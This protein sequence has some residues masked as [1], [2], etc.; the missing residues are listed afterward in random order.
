MKGVNEMTKVEINGNFHLLKQK[1]IS[2]F[3]MERYSE[4]RRKWEN[5][6]LRKIVDRFPIHLDI[7]ATSACNLKCPFCITTHANFENGL[8]KDEMFQAIIDEGSE[9]GLCS[10][11]LN[12]RGEPLVHPK[13]PEMI[14]YAKAKGIVDVFLNTNAAFLT[15]TKSRQLINAG[16]DRIIISFEGYEKDLYESQRVGAI[17]EETVENVRNFMIIRREL[18]KTLPWVRIQTVLLDE[19]ENKQADYADFWEE[20]VDEVAYVDLKNEVNRIAVGENDWVCPQLWQRLTISWDGRIMPCVNDTFCNM[21]LGKILKTSI[22]DVWKSERLQEM[23]DLH[24]KGLAHT[25]KDCLDCP[26][27]SAQVSR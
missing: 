3:E 9:K 12:W 10:I 16:V 25:I 4:Y 21:C 2:P 26:L 18:N 8:M 27:R 5:Y 7:E 24:T 1:G 14:A 6:P 11:K 19:L 17:F 13:L 23:R 22:E 20:Y 15:E